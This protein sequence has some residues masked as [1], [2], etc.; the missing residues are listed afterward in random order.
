MNPGSVGRPAD[1]NPQAAY[2]IA[3]FNPFSVELLRIDYDVA[4]AAKALR[5]K[6]LPE[7]FSQM[8]LCG[9]AVDDV[10][11]EDRRRK[12]AINRDY[13]EVVKNCEKVSE[14]YGQD[15]EHYQQVRKLSLCLFDQLRNLHRLGN[16]ERCLLECA[17]TLHDIGILQTTKA[18][19]KKSMELIL[20]DTRLLLPSEERR[21]VASI[22]RY[23]RGGFPKKKHYNL[24]SLNTKA[25][26][27]ITLL[28]GIL[29]M[30]DSLDYSH[31]RIVEN[32]TVKKG[33]K[34]IT[35]E[36]TANS[37]P[38]LEQQAFNKKKDLIEKALKTKMVLVWKQR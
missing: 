25:V 18:H 9:V 4:A 33:A 14:Q 6:G 2:A 1:K 21:I 35:I 37:D 36:C 29:R 19:N 11:K 34:K 17:S 8:L 22:A 20:N 12:A 27:K 31:S 3:K 28:S 5:K 38:T 26:R 23:H 24:K 10:T 7:S 30:A 13:Q 15:T 32:L 16:V